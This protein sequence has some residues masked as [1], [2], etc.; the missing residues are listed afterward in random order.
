VFA[1]ARD[2]LS[3]NQFCSPSHVIHA[4]FSPVGTLIGGPPSRR[5]PLA[6][7]QVHL[8]ITGRG[9]IVEA[10]VAVEP[11]SHMRYL[12]TSGL[13]ASYRV[14]IGYFQPFDVW[15]AIATSYDVEMPTPQG[16]FDITD[17][18]VA[19]I[20]FHL[21]FQQLANLLGAD[22]NAPTARAVSDF[23]K[24]ALRNDKP[25][26]GRRFDTQ[27]L[28]SLNVSLDEITAGERSFKRLDMQKLTR[29]AR[30]MCRF[31][32]ASPVSGFRANPGS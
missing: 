5:R 1:F 14:E 20:P 17:A 32:A 25:N 10:I 27:I 16:R 6:D 21:N 12:R 28:S 11:M 26:E 15:R 22:H 30:A 29:Q 8:R 18:E 24:R 3:E 19:T 9:G 7:R 13:H 2:R 4:L 23:E 31:A